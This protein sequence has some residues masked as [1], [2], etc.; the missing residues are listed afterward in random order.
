[1]NV[2]NENELDKDVVPSHAQTRRQLLIKEN[3][4]NINVGI[5][6]VLTAILIAAYLAMIFGD[7]FNRLI[8]KREIFLKKFLFLKTLKIQQ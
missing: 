4:I 8:S 5:L 6:S 3:Q 1:M 2:V 7:P